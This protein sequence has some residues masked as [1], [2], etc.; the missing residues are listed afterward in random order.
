V[1][2]F[3]VH[4]ERMVYP[5]ASSDFVAIYL[6]HKVD[7]MPVYF[8]FVDYDERLDAPIFGSQ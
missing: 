7:Q 5:V 2:V 6:D 4:D 3:F 8:D 1:K